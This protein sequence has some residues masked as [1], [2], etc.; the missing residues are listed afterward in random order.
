[1][2]VAGRPVVGVPVE[3]RAGAVSSTEHFADTL[4]RMLYLS[5]EARR[6]R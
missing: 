4:K 6:T 2:Q 3:S 5:P 1:V